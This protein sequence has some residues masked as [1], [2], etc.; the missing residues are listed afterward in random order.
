MN[1]AGPKRVMLVFGT[2]PE[3]IK[4]A[5]VVQALAA[6]PQWFEPVVVVT[7]QHREMLDQVLSIFRLAPQYDL[8]IM[9][10]GQTLS[11]VMI[12][13]LERLDPVL[14]RERPDMVLV[15]GDAHSCLVGALAAYYHQIPIGHVEAGLRTGDKY[16]PFPEEANRRLTDTLSDLCFAPTTWARDNL[17]RENTPVE[18]ILVTG[19]T[20]I[21]ALLTVVRP[22]YAYHVTLPPVLF[23]PGRRLVLVE[24]HRRENFGRAMEEAFAALG[25][26]ARTHPD[27][28]MVVSV[29]PNPNVKEPARRWLSGQARV[30]L[31]EPF[32]YDDWANLMS[33]AYLLITDS[34]GLQEEAP[35]VGTPVLVYRDVTERP[36]AVAAGTVRLVGTGGEKLWQAAHEFLQDKI[37]HDDM[38]HRANPYGDGRASAR[39]V[40]GLAH[41]FGFTH[42]PPEEFLV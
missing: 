4:M 31:Y 10:P 1:N 5:P 25:E 38:A 2:R 37:M 9:L 26:V 27:V 33:R 21:D 20:V 18:R 7:G 24:L 15:H 12:R 14:E 40:Q 11:D 8:D 28:E 29:H 19:N 39:I 17:L 35:A 34:G 30:H 3:A 32:L 23:D 22:G 42:A 41:Y 16:H 36:E 6:V 13:G